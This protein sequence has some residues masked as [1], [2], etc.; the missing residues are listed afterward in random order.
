MATGGCGISALAHLFLGID[1]GGVCVCG[2]KVFVY[3]LDA[4]EPALRDVLQ[5]PPEVDADGQRGEGRERALLVI[6]APT[7]IVA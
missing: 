2:R 5:E 7:R 6:A 1:Y 3:S 4:E